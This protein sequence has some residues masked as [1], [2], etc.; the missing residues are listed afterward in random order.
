[1]LYRYLRLFWIKL[2]FTEVNTNHISLQLIG[3]QN[4]VESILIIHDVD[5]CLDASVQIHDTDSRHL[6]QLIWLSLD[7]L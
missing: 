3:N 7:L 1:M 4:I 5:V 6:L 2:S